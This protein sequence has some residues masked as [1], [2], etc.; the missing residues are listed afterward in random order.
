MSIVKRKDIYDYETRVLLKTLSHFGFFLRKSTLR[1]FI[2]ELYLMYIYIVHKCTVQMKI[3]LY[4][5][6]ANCTL[7]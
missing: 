4:Y 5:G 1:S 7:K 6:A 3:P 2:G